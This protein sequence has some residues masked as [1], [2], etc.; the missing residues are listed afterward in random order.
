MFP[1]LKEVKDALAESFP[2][3]VNVFVVQF[4]C[5]LIFAIFGMILY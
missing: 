2:D 4:L 3:L 1:S 5:W